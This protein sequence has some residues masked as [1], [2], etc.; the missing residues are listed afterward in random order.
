[1]AIPR[2]PKGERPY[3]RRRGEMMMILLGEGGAVNSVTRG[4]KLPSG[5]T[6]THA[7]AHPNAKKK[8]I[9]S[10]LVAS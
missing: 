3:E 2:L 6:Q 8:N 1:M 10:M 5:F 4:K 7:D 9:G